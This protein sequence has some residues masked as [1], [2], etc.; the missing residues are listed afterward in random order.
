MSQH[1]HNAA[2]EELMPQTRAAFVEGLRDGLPF[3]IVYVPFAMLFGVV[4]T[5]AGL[6]VAQVLGMSVLIIAGAAQFAAISQISDAAPVLIVIATA[7]AVNI[8]M[9]MYSASLVPYLGAAPFW[10]RAFAAY[11]LVDQTYVMGI[12]K[13][14]ARGDWSVSA[15]Y[16]YFF[17]I[18]A[19]LAPTW[20]VAT[21]FGA[22][23]GAAIPPEFALDFAVPITF[24]A[25]TAPLLKSLAHLA[26]AASSVA[27]SLALTSLPFGTGLLIA[28]A[29]AMVIGALV[30]TWMERA[31]A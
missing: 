19:P 14:E 31:Q 1:S 6:N 12:A 8:R 23:V 15:R 27:L 7:L 21:Y 29:C 18:I 9:A 2:E 13:Y 16:A 24:V 5:E 25:M 30:E 4:A 28:A 3:L 26:A 22:V 10:K 17:G 20:Y 11:L